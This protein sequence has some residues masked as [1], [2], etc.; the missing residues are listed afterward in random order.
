MDIAIPL[1]VHPSEHRVGLTPKGVRLLVQAGHRCYLQQGAGEG[2]GFPD[3][4]YEKAGAR[5]VYAAQEVYSRADLVLKVG[6]PT[7]EELPF[8]RD[9]QTIA[10]FW[11]LAARPRAITQA[12]LEQGI[13]A[14]AYERI[15]TNGSF[16]VLRT[17]S[18]IA[19]R[20]TPQIAA[21]WLQNDGGGRGILISGLPGIPPTD[22]IIVGAGT[23]GV[24][25]ARAF[26][27]MGA[28]VFMLDESLERLQQVEQDFDGRVV[29]MVAYDFNVARVVKFADILVTAARDPG[30][31]R[32]PVLVTRE[33][34]RSMRPRSL[35]MDIA[36]DEGG[37]VETSRPTTHA[38]P[39]FVEEGITH[40]CVPNISGVVAWTATNAYLNA[41]WPYI[42]SMAE[43]GTAA[44]IETDAGLRHGAVVHEGQ[45]LDPNLA[46]LLEEV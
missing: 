6:T 39:I 41:A 35:V 21:R 27:R 43:K 42:Q 8:L 20:M 18:E 36:I 31:A 10:A 5:M 38:D 30:G 46:M 34:V 37:N 13:T 45:V 9:G 3:A 23:V 28:R 1:E 24:N 14:I 7:L 40:Y 25:A 32:A 11:H 26:M 17:L 12:V 44:A 4:E 29:T 22:V 15:Q 19:G 16:P 2:A 33:M